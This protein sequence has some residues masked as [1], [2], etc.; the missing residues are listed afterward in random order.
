MGITRRSLLRWGASGLGL[1]ALAKAGELDALADPG[2][3]VTTVPRP[4]IL[5]RS[6]WAKGSCPVKGK[7][8]AEADVRFL[9]VHHTAG[10]NGYSRSEVPAMLRGWYRYH[11]GPEKKWPDIAYN[12]LIDSYG[13]IWEG[14]QGSAT[15]AVRGSATGGNQGFDQLICFIGSFGRITPS[16]AALNAGVELI[17]WLGAVYDI[18]LDAGRSISFISRGSNRWKKG[19]KVTTRPV[20]GHRDMSL[21]TCP[22]DKLYPLIGSRLTPLAAEIVRS[23]R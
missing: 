4:A 12:F 17:A 6:A 13:R 22:G 14:R 10:K 20:A 15:A 7:L 2:Q 5:P 8:V 19:R 1:A 23:H 16:K 3:A 11:T 9:L 21:T 18:D